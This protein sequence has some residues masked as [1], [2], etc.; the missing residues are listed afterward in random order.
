MEMLKSA[1]RVDLTHVPYKG[2]GQFVPA[3]VAG[4]VASVI[5]AINSL[6]P[7]VKA[8]RLRALAMAGAR[9]TPLLPG[10]P[11]IA[12]AALPGY[13]LDNWGGILTPAGTPRAVI[14]RLNHEIVRTLGDPRVAERLASQGVEITPSTPEAFDILL[15]EHAAKW[16]RIVKA[17]HIQLQY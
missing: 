1:A 9:R 11:T 6:L 3:L 2:A 4:E 16:A 15:K 8:G 14:G 12:E 13:V 10:V 17:A 7:H 5:G